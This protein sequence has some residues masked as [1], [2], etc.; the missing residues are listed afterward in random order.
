[1]D[2]S[3][4][5]VNDLDRI[6]CTYSFRLDQGSAIPSKTFNRVRAALTRRKCF[7]NKVDKRHNEYLLVK[8]ET[9]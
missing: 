2:R 5:K 6:L 9:A 7:P 1:M 8:T 3:V 4:I